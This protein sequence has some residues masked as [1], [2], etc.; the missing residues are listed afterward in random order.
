MKITRIAAQERNPSRRNLYV[1]DV[2]AL[3][4]SAE[5]LLRFGLRAGD[6]ITHER[7][8]EI[9]Q[10][11]ELV[12]ARGTALRYLGVR[13]RTEKEMRDKL[14]ER[15]FGDEEIAK[16]IADL[17]AAR[18]IDDP[19]FARMYIRDTMMKRPSGAIMLRRK[20]LLLGVNRETVDEA[21]QE[22]L[23]AVNLE[24][25]ALSVAREF[26]R[27]TRNLRKGESPRKLRSRAASHLARRGFGWDVIQ[28][29]LKTLLGDEGS[30]EAPSSDAT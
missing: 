7:L 4:V 19:A 16:T 28:G 14:R 20:L 2:F 25:Q 11:E 1:D 10:T 3:G 8:R 26:V 13:P 15:E 23:S 17:R 29:A 18:L 24:E 5:T 9:E 30:P 21:I 22:L 6:E 12:N 27:K